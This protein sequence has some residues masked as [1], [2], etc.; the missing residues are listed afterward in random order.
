MQQQKYALIRRLAVGGMAELFL[1]RCVGSHGF[2]KTVVLKRILPSFAE[3]PAFTTMFLAEARLAAGLDHPNIAHV[4]DFGEADGSYYFAMEYVRGQ[5]LRQIVRAARKAERAIPLATVIHIITGVLAGLHHA[6]EHRDVEG[7]PLEVVHRDV[8][9]ANA[10]VT[11]EGFVKVV[12]FGIAKAAAL[13]PG[14][15]AGTLKGKISYMSPEQCRGEPVDRRSDI[16]SVGT[17]LWELTVGKRLF[18]SAGADNELALLRKVDEAEVPK[19]TE[20]VPGYPEWLEAIVLKALSR[21]REDRYQSAL[22]LRV[23]LEDAAR[24]AMLPISSAHTGRLMAELFPPEERED[25]VSNSGDF[26]TPIPESRPRKVSATHT[27]PGEE[28][29]RTR[30]ETPSIRGGGTMIAPPPEELDEPPRRRMMPLVA[31]LGVLLLIGGVAATVLGGDDDAPAAESK[32]D[33]P[34]GPKA[35]AAGAPLGDAPSGGADVAEPAAKPEP[36]PPPA[37][38]DDVQPAA[39]DGA[40]PAA[41]QAEGG[42]APDAEAEPAPAAEPKPKSKPKSKS[43]PKAKSKPASSETKQASA[44]PT[45]PPEPPKAKPKAEPKPDGGD[46]I[47]MAPDPSRRRGA[48]KKSGFL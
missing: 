37:V 16:F 42:A 32:G 39:A 20:L 34:E 3:N 27:W 21:D 7:R 14:T 2:S 44:E 26:G 25:L 45:P 6:H 12:D 24:E 28:G 38:V 47:F 13:G 36:T 35:A 19:P 22:E 4:F 15:V 9:P 1:A 48:K 41:A 8:S 29:S 5:D 31:S 43:K 10:L 17:L 18:G 33:V 46:D 23:A 30:P 11:Y 40:D